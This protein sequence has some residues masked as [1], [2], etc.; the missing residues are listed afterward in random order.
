M[1]R[2]HMA[3]NSGVHDLGTMNGLLCVVAA[4]AP[5][6]DPLHLLVSSAASAG[7]LSC[8]SGRDLVCLLFVSF[9]VLFSISKRQCGR[10]GS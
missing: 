8:V 5:S 9:P 1:L 2:R 4:G 7:F 3:Y 10:L 6:H